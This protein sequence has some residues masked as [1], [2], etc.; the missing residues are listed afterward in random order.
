MTS[1]TDSDMVQLGVLFKNVSKA[2][3]TYFNGKFGDQKVVGFLNSFTSKSGE[4]MTVINLYEAT[5]TEDKA[6]KTTKA[7]KTGDIP[8]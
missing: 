4:D 3:K 5:E 1:K 8:F 2:G 7:K 6:K